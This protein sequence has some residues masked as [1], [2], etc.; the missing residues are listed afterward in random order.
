MKRQSRRQK[1]EVRKQKSE[2]RN[3]KAEIR[4]QKCKHSSIIHGLSLYRAGDLCL[5]AGLLVL[6]CF[7]LSA[8]FAATCSRAN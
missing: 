1:A 4:K 2:S 3:Q 8:F 5:P 6:F 7:L